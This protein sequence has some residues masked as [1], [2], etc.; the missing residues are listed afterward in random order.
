MTHRLNAPRQRFIS[1]LAIALLCTAVLVAGCNKETLRPS[2]PGT[3]D[4]FSDARIMKTSS[5]L[6]TDWYD[7]QTRIMLYAN[8]NP[9]P[10]V[11]G[12]FF[13]YEGIALY[14]SIRNGIPGAVPLHEVLYQMPEMPAKENNN[15]YAWDLAA[16][17]ALARITKIMLPGL[18]PANLAS[19][20]SL[21][22]ENYF[23]ANPDEL[24]AVTRRSIEFGRK[25]ADAVFEWSKS[26]G[27]ARNSEP[28]TIPSFPGSW[29][30]TPPAML[31]P[32]LP[33]LGTARPLLEMHLTGITP[34]FP[35]A[36]SETPGS[37]F[38]NEVNF[39]YQTAK[40]ATNEQKT[41]AR[42]WADVG[43]GTGYSTPGHHM[44]ILTNLL[45]MYDADLGTAAMAY[46]KTGIA[47]RDGFIMTWRS[48]YSYNM[49]RPVSYVRQFI[50]PSW[51]PFITTPNHPEY[52]AAHAS[53][54]AAFMEAMAGVF[55]DNYAF[56]D[57]TYEFLGIPPRHYNTFTEAATEAGWSRVYGGIHYR[58]SV[59]AG[60]AF[61]KQ[62]GHHARELKLIR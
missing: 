31:P 52:P 59:E 13:A 30:P 34:P 9:S 10:I 49:I 18:T 3:P 28:Y 6:V 43:V 55:G 15:G 36:Y 40:N 53:V 25:I 42:F 50:D 32:A 23:Q 35:Y 22:A 61:G 51:L 45:Q 41:I 7:L 27:I 33:Y 4:S 62:I 47:L 24:S 20:D 48:K 21:E 44:K 16:N 46:L 5:E 14:E 8:P 12:R 11:T 58:K 39:T 37:D 26:D 2:E 60:L 17:A 19:I 56:S 38:Y 1:G 29:S 57:N 54:T